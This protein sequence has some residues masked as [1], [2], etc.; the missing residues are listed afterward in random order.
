MRAGTAFYK[1][2]E[3]FEEDEGV[4]GVH[5]LILRSTPEFVSLR[6]SSS[7]SFDSELRGRFAKGGSLALMRI[8]FIDIRNTEC[9]PGGELGSS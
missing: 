3:A 1:M 5:R 6:K 2:R 8:S 7:S 4:G 9:L